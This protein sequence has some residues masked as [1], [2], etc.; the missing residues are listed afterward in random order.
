MPGLEQ[1]VKK[2]WDFVYVADGGAHKNH[3]TLLKSW[4]H[5]AQAGI[6][7][8]LALTLSKRDQHLWDAIKDAS[9]RHDLKISNLGAI[10]H[11]EVLDLYTRTRALVYPSLS[12]SFGL[13]LIEARTVGLP[14]L[15]G[16]LDFVRDVCVP[17][18]TFDPTSHVSIARAVRRYL[19]A[20]DAPA[21]LASASDFLEICSQPQD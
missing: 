18:E 7:P 1:A 3:E 16:E 15:A 17:V 20:A 13:P 19:Q 11:K 21:P 14:I 12:E 2:D 4:I 8:S 9:R 6:R 10:P 5:L